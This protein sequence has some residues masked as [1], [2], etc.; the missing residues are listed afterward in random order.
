MKLNITFLLLFAGL[1][2]SL[3]QSHVDALRYSQHSIGGTARSVA[4]GGAFGALGGDFSTLSNNPAGLGVYRASEFTFTPEL[5]FKNTTSR[6]FG[7]VV[8]ESKTNF[9]ISNLGYVANIPIK[10]GVLKA[11]NMGIGF[12]RLANFHRNSVIDGDNPSTS[13]GHYQA[14]LSN[15]YGLD[16]FGS[17]LF[18]DAYVIDYDNEIGYFLNDDPDYGYYE[19]GTFRETEQRVVNNE[20]GRIN[21]WTFSMGFNFNEFFYV[22]GTLGWHI[23]RYT[24]DRT[25]KEYDANFREYNYFNYNES[26]DVTG[27]GFAAK[28]GFILKP[29]NFLRIGASVH[30]PV[31]YNL[32][33][34]YSTNI[35]SVFLND[36]T[37]VLYPID[38]NGNNIEY[39]ENEY[40]VTTPA[41][42]TASAAVVMGK[43]LIVSADMDYINYASMRMGPVSDF[44]IENENIAVIYKDALNIKSG[45]ELRL[46]KTYLRGGIGFYGSPYAE[47]EEN[48]DAYRISYTGGLGIRDEVFFFDIAYQYTNYDEREILYQVNLDGVDYA[49]S[50]NLDMKAHRIMATMGWRF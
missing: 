8:E 48:W 14:G 3:S 31:Y 29:V 19:N 24:M 38:E 16:A 42:L 50:A 22:G 37:E 12:N 13:F 7:N 20:T 46:G 28:F 41:K 25:F 9:N 4:M 43:F 23:V 47:T 34:Q 18:Y 17:A 10:E 36:N 32:N 2:N 45:T 6:Y 33:E 27:N 1:L 11:L 44:D 49:P 5:Y 21:E 30:S 40:Q 26:L 35:S 15:E 39:L